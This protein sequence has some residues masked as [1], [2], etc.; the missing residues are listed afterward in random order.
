MLLLFFLLLFLIKISGASYICKDNGLTF[1]AN[2][3]ENSFYEEGKDL[4]EYI[5][6][7]KMN[8]SVVLSDISCDYNVDI[9]LIFGDEQENFEENEISLGK[10]SKSYCSD[11][12]KYE[13]PENTGIRVKIYNKEEYGISFDFKRN[14]N[15]TAKCE[16]PIKHL[17]ANQSILLTSQSKSERCVYRLIPSE[18]SEDFNEILIEDLVGDIS[19]EV[20]RHDENGTILET[21]EISQTQFF[22]RQILDVYLERNY[23]SSKFE[24]R[25]SLA[26]RSCNCGPSE[27]STNST[28]TTLRSPGFPKANCHHRQC[29]YSLNFDI[30]ENSYQ[31]LYFN[32]ITNLV[33]YDTLTISELSSHNR[34]F[35]ENEEF[36]K[37]AITPRNFVVNYEASSTISDRSFEI[38]ITKIDILEQCRCSSYGD[39]IYKTSRGK[40]QLRIPKICQNIFCHWRIQRESDGYYYRSQSDKE[41]LVFEISLESG[42]PND[43]LTFNQKKFYKSPHK[44]I[45]STK[46]FPV[47][48]DFQRFE[49]NV[50]TDTNITVTWKKT[51]DC[52]CPTPFIQ[53][54]E[55][56][57][58]ILTS[59]NY[60][61]EYCVNMNCQTNLK[62]EN[63]TQIEIFIE[64]LELEN[65]HDYLK[66]DNNSIELTGTYRNYTIS[67][68]KNEVDLRFESDSNEQDNGFF[69]VLRSRKVEEKS[70]GI[71]KFLIFLML[72]VIFILLGIGF[73]KY[74]HI[75]LNNTKENGVVNY[76]NYAVE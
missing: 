50:L 7:P 3:T 14:K 10:I 21:E 36:K 19:Y 30:L 45:F 4:C 24:W 40:I 60:P 76:Q 8:E 68:G 13:S 58:I 2:F 69:I 33:E 37:F 29:Y 22:A 34:I 31:I 54:A 16:F 55:N 15:P 39:K 44:S 38:N 41:R 49:I 63:E 27:V 9:W 52:V 20:R 23:D 1:A 61:D 46:N 57:S 47:D 26:H 75:F 12:Y 32:I 18:H 59:P 42:N 43:F 11:N 62:S 73:L 67:T 74:R 5:F 28:I 72:F 56:Q 66:I 6:V 35:R 70:T 51:T 65:F 64:K 17:I 71:S 53:I 25:A 48:I